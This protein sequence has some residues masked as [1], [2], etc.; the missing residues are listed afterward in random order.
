LLDRPTFLIVILQLTAL[1]KINNLTVEVLSIRGNRDDLVCRVT[2]FE[3][4]NK[5]NIFNS[6]QE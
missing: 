1:F 2:T 5:G 4:E 6:Y 3:L